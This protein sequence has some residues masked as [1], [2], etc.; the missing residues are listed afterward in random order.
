MFRVNEQEILDSPIAVMNKLRTSL[1]ESGIDL[2]RGIKES[3]SN[4]QFTCPV[5]NDGRESKP[6]C[7]ITTVAKGN[8]EAGTV[9]CFACGY[10]SSL[11]EMISLCFGKEDFGRYGKKWLTENF[12]IA[13]R[14]EGREPLRTDFT[15][16][17]AKDKKTF[18]L[19]DELDKF[20]YNHPYQY[21]RGLT[22]EI[23]ELFDVGYDRRTKC[24][25]FPV[26][27]DRNRCL[28]IARR[29]VD[30]KFFSYPKE[31]QKPV[32]GLY[33]MNKAQPKEV[34]VCESIFNALTCWVYGKIGVAML[35]L[36]TEYQYQQL[37]SSA[38]RKFICAFDPDEAGEQ[39]SQRFYRALKNDKVVT[40]YKI[41]SGKDVND[42]TKEEFDN[43]NEFYF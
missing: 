6:S 35:G 4:I 30:T 29:S 23:I 26:T 1:L 3:G 38:V 36:G 21:K 34:I 27:D 8:T 18:I 39:A 17:K 31:V 25:T 33:Q 16:A 22:D 40:R 7:G 20:R 43:L 5:H 42:L 28:F 10:T 14:G 9:H 32:Y 24:V 41:P 19:D 2:L 37:R 15:R 12:I 13:E 11:E